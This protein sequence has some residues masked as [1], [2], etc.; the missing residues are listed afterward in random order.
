MTSQVR[1]THTPSIPMQQYP[2]QY[3][4]E[5]TAG[6]TTNDD[7]TQKL[8]WENDLSTSAPRKSGF[9]RFIRSATFAWICCAMFVVLSGVREVHS[10]PHNPF[11]TTSTTSDVASHPSS[12]PVP[13]ASVPVTSI[14]VTSA[15]DTSAPDISA[16]KIVNERPVQNTTTPQRVAYLTMFSETV[17][18][19][20]GEEYSYDTD[21]YFIATRMLTY[22]L[23]HA[24]ETKTQRSIPFIIMVT[25]DVSEAKREQ[26]RQDGAIIHPI[27]RITDGFDWMNVTD[28]PI[29]WRDQLSKLR[30]WELEQYDRI[31]YV[32]S[33]MVLMRCLDGIFDADQANTTLVDTMTNPDQISGDEAPM[34]KQYLMAS[35]PETWDDYLYPPGSADISM[36]TDYINGGFFMFK[37]NVSMLEYYRSG[38]LTTSL[39][40]IRIMIFPL[41]FERSRPTQGLL[42]PDLHGTIPAQP[43]P[44][45]GRQYAVAH[46]AHDLEPDQGQQ[47]VHRRS[48][49]QHSR[50][51]V[52]SESREFTA[53]FP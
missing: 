20:S 4:D 30:A 3:H 14:P 36:G 47:R 5:E 45:Q 29:A 42:Q 6:R 7:Y 52:E 24:P 9:S 12:V 10:N 32:D 27:E 35:M 44:S 25:E 38:T 19:Q 48:R 1:E 8:A 37:P 16:E 26:L 18:T 41:T 49:G 15:A 21:N 22:Q 28:K 40:H 46:P 39:C 13:V 23:V 2:G 51:M 50:Q 11:R 31:L 33:D 34:P 53:N 17:M 43:R